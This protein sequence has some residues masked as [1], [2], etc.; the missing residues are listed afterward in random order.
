[1]QSPYSKQ[2]T[3]FAASSRPLLSAS[4]FITIFFL[5]NL[6]TSLSSQVKKQFTQDPSAARSLHGVFIFSILRASKIAD[7]WSVVL[8]GSRHKPQIV[9]HAIPPLSSSITKL[10][11][12]VIEIDDRDFIKFITGALPRLKGVSPAKSRSRAI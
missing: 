4:Y 5:T 3:A 12:V 7:E 10:L 8:R 9:H 11:V 2:I 1:M 6:K